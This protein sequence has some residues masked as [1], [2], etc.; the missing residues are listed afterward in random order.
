MGVEVGRGGAYTYNRSMNDD[1]M[2]IVSIVFLKMAFL[3]VGE[4]ESGTKSGKICGRLFRSGIRGFKVRLSL[5]CAWW[6]FICC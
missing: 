6:A 1:M 4:D 3:F 5:A 2:R